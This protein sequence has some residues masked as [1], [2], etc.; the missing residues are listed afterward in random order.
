MSSHGTPQPMTARKGAPLSGTA[1]LDIESNFSSVFI[2]SVA[3]VNADSVTNDGVDLDPALTTLTLET[4]PEPAAA[5][6]LGLGIAGLALRRR[7]A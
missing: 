4:V 3:L 7:G 1:H 5:L 2:L 6:L